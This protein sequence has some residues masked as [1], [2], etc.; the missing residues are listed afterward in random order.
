MFRY[1]LYNITKRKENIISFCLS[2]VTSFVMWRLVGDSRSCPVGDLTTCTAFS[3]NHYSRTFHRFFYLAVVTCSL[4]IQNIQNNQKRKSCIT[5]SA[6]FSGFRVSS[7]QDY[8][9]YA[10]YLYISSRTVSM[11]KTL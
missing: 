3:V 5:V 10:C 9:R 11:D 1:S 2:I 6:I 7:Y 4:H 8:E